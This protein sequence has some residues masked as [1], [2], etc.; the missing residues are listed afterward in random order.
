MSALKNRDISLYLNSEKQS[1]RRFLTLYIFLVLALISLLSV[2]YYKSQEKLMFS[3]QRTVLSG[4]ATEQVKRLKILHH[5]FPTR[6]KYPR[7]RRFKSAIYDIERV[8][9]FSTLDNNHVNMDKVIYRAGNKIHF[10]KTLDDYYLGAMY[11][12]LEID[13]DRAWF[14]DTIWNII[15]LGTIMLI[16]L[17]IFGLFFVR[18]FLKPMKNSIELL[19]NFIKDTTHELNTP[20][21]AILANVEMM[22]K[23]IMSEKNIKKLARI[24]IAAKTVSHLYQD[25][26]YLVLGHQR[27]SKDEWIDLK[28]LILNRVDYFHILSKSKKISFQLDL[29]DSKLLID[30]VKIARMIDNL[31]SNAIK[32]NKRN[33]TIQIVLRD[34]YV[35]ISDTGIGINSDKVN[36]IFDRYSRF[37]NSAGGFG[38]GLNIVK[39]IA[40]EYNLKIT[41]SSVLGEGTTFRV[42]FPKGNKK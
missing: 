40:D 3:N 7:D 19:D 25:L 23:S 32:Y 24:N 8:L 16:V 4:Y 42:E 28:K 17:A 5:Y 26:T 11:L 15:A 27:I 22:D 2:S 12:I 20:I 39:S 21:S 10:V 38:I 6:Y 37:T 35:L 33:G 1:L 30:P 29:E 18:L 13:E 36:S 41:V 9:I 34:E 14:R 31:I